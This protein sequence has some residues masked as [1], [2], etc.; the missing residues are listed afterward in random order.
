MRWSEAN[1]FRVRRKT[2]T[3]QEVMRNALGRFTTDTTRNT[4]NEPRHQPRTRQYSTTPH[5]TRS[6]QCPHGVEQKWDR[7]DRCHSRLGHS[8][9]KSK[10]N[11]TARNHILR[12]SREQVPA[13]NG[14]SHVPRGQRRGHTWAG[15]E[16]MF[17]VPPTMFD[18]PQVAELLGRG[19]HLGVTEGAP[20]TLRRD[21]IGVLK[22]STQ[23]R[24]PQR[25]EHM[26]QARR[27]LGVRGAQAL[28]QEQAPRQRVAERRT[29]KGP[30]LLPSAT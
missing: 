24:R 8:R 3:H 13:Q 4:K 5:T 14:H 27:E 17:N 20:F 23:V 12:R 22:I 11:N 21:T 29:N 16:E 9:R 30:V 10:V 18:L 7:T 1:K 26:S 2:G 25:E 19:V 28:I 15:Q 6:T